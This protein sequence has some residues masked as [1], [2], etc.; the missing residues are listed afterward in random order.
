M[1]EL[2][3]EYITNA[4][5]QSEPEYVEVPCG[6]QFDFVLQVGDNGLALSRINA[7]D[8]VGIVKQDTI[9]NGQIAAVLIDD[10]T[11]LLRRVFVRNNLVLLDA[12]APF[13]PLVFKGEEIQRIS[14]IGRA[15]YAWFDLE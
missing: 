5:A 2:I 6:M 7:G 13:E 4:S 9:E 10:E 3:Q 15:V 1:Q 8:M 14:I 12:D 11:L